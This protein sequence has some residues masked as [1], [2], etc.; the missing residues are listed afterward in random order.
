MRY[1]ATVLVTAPLLGLIGHFMTAE[2]MPWWPDTAIFGAFMG[3]LAA[4]VAM[5]ISHFRKAGRHL[6]GAGRA[7]WSGVRRKN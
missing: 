1:L 3:A 6:R 7:A 5:R 2:P 4:F